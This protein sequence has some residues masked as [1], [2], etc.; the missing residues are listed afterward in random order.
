LTALVEVKPHL[1][2]AELRKRFRACDDVLERA[3]LQA[4]W[5]RARGVSTLAVADICG[6][7]VDWVRRLVRRYNARGPEALKD[8]RGSNGKQRLLSDAQLE[9]L[10]SALLNEVP[11]GGGL[12]TGPKVAAW[13]SAKL[14]RPISPQLAWDY[15]QRL[16]FSK[17]VPRP[18][19]TRA[20]A[21]AQEEFKK[22]SAVG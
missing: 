16:E 13:M 6:F 1:S 22:N 14:D 15:L 11:P 7:N 19:H 21:K 9:E 17:Q 8:G 18:R 3:H 2:I 10:R 4:I 20:S 5:L 12:W